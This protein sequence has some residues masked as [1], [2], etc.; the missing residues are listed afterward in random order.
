[1]EKEE[2]LLPPI[3]EED[4]MWCGLCYPFWFIFSPWTLK[5]DKKK[6][7]FV[8]FHALQGLH[9]GIFTSVTTLLAFLIAYLVF[10]R[11][12]IERLSITTGEQLNSRLMCGTIGVVVLLGSM[13]F[14]TIIL[15]MT[16]Y[17]GWRAASGK[18]FRI[19][20]IG[21][22][23]WNTVYSKKQEVEA[24][25]YSSPLGKMEL[26]AKERSHIIPEKEI[27][28]PVQEESEA[29]HYKAPI[30]MKPKGDFEK[31]VPL[32]DDGEVDYEALLIQSPP[33]D[34]IKSI[35]SPPPEEII[36]EEQPEEEYIPYDETQ[37]SPLE[38]LALLRKQKAEEQTQAFEESI[39]DEQV[40]EET[41]ETSQAAYEIPETGKDLISPTTKEEE[42]PLVFRED[43]QDLS[44]E[45][46]I[47]LLRQQQNIEAKKTQTVPHQAVVQ[48]TIQEEVVET[49][50]ARP[51]SF[52]D[53]KE[54]FLR[55]QQQRLGMIDSNEKEPSD[56]L[57]QVVSSAPPIEHLS[58]LEQLSQMRKQHRERQEQLGFTNE[59]PV[60]KSRKIPRAAS[61]SRLDPSLL[62]ANAGRKKHENAPQ[63]EKK[64]NQDVRKHLKDDSM[65]KLS[66]L[67]RLSALRKRQK[68]MEEA[69]KSSAIP[70]EEKEPALEKPRPIATTRL[71]P[72]VLL[73]LSG[74]SKKTGS[75]GK[76]KGKKKEK[77]LSHLEKLAKL[78]QK[79][80]KKIIGKTKAVSTT[81]KKSTPVSRKDKKK[82]S[83]LEQL[84]LRRKEKEQ[85]IQEK[86]E[87]KLISIQKKSSKMKELLNK[88][89]NR[90]RTYQ[91]ER[92]DEKTG[93]NNT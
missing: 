1:M 79:K 43:F 36:I 4:W 41:I 27:H 65:K 53:P 86:N 49:P 35:F 31:H 56:E 39:E 64:S 90:G 38:K 11:P 47:T 77:P 62:F 32:R 37:L 21:K 78:Q 42:V 45:E 18:M 69:K 9:F 29:S 51:T 5:T 34:K 14:L 72:S 60:K 87:E 66:H 16:L 26:K 76:K 19:P 12:N 44:Q 85:D 63:T 15:F 88:M 92:M 61:T 74:K 7:L 84:A 54:A 71:D 22:Y 46:Q 24:D 93:E 48:E 82:L 10:F 52:L 68:E 57:K 33:I 50:P 59:E 17:Y 91:G 2:V 6:E 81:K 8:Y 67:Q 25:Y 58:P 89:K 73:S 23:A 13:L 20:F 80:Q 30:S 70:S 3:N 55:I 40:Q 75:T 28:E 83:P